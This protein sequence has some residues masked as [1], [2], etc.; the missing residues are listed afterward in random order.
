MSLHCSTHHSESARPSVTWPLSPLWLLWFLSPSLTDFPCYSSALVLS[1]S[2]N[3]VSHKLSL[4]AA[5]PPWG[6][7][8]KGTC[9]METLKLQLL[10]PNSL[11]TSLFFFLLQHL[12]LSNMLHKLPFL[13]FFGLVF[14]LFNFISM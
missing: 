8:S 2:E 13:L 14:Y 4:P 11:F 5:S 6:P 12:S 1:S 9:I 10:L 3:P 7:Y